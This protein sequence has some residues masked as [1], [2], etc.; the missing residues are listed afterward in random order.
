M[1]DDDRDGAH[2]CAARAWVEQ[3]EP[4]EEADREDHDNSDANQR[5]QD[6]QQVHIAQLTLGGIF[7][8]QEVVAGKGRNTRVAEGRRT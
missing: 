5:E 4:N 1:V 2:P 8:A 3:D 7:D 6:Y